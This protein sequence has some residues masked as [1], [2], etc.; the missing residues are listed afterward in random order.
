M[1]LTMVTP[2]SLMGMDRLTASMATMASLS[3]SGRVFL[4]SAIKTRRS[5]IEGTSS[6]RNV[7]SLC[8][9]CETRGQ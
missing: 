9:V 3:S 5:K 7:R 4:S 1:E 2:A 8:K 6:G